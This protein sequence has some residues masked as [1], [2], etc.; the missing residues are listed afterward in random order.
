MRRNW[1]KTLIPLGI[2]VLVGTSV[3]SPVAAQ[4]PGSTFAIAG[5][6]RPARILVDRWGVP[7]VYAQTARD[8]FLAQGFNAARDRLFQIDLW[9]RKGLGRLSE[10][11][12]PDFVDQDRAARLFR[13]RGDMRAEWESYGPEGRLAATR[14]ANG[15]NAYLDWLDRNASA[16]PEEFRKL[17]YKPARWAP[18]DVVTIRA[19]VLSYNLDSEIE[20]AR[21]ACAAGIEADRV[22]VR[23]QPEHRPQ[24]PAGFDP[25][26]LPEDVLDVFNLA[27]GDLQFG[28]DDQAKAI[29][30]GVNTQGSNAWTLGPNRTTTGRPILANDPHRSVS[31]PSPRYLAHLSAPGLNVIGAGEP[32]APG[33]SIGHNDTAGFGLTVS[34]IDQEDLYVYQLD[35]ADPGRYR[36]RDGWENLTKVTEEIPVAGAAPRKVELAFTRHGPVIKVDSQRNLAYAVRAAWLEP[37]MSP[38]YGSLRY[39]RAKSFGEFSAA[40]GNWGAPG[41]N[42]V[43]ADTRGDIGLT[44]SGRAPRRTGYDGLLPVPGDGR[45]EWTGYVPG[46]ELPRYHNPEQGFLATGNEYNLPPGYPEKLGYEWADPSRYDRIAEVLAGKPKSSVDDSIRLQSDQLSPI[47]RSLLPKLEQLSSA[48]PSAAAALR[49]LRGWDAVEHDRSA[50]A[51]LFEVWLIG[52]LGPR[53]TR[54]IL[55]SA[56]ADLVPFPDHTVLIEAM[57]QPDKWFGPGGAAKRDK[58]LLDSLK[59]AYQDAAKRLGPDPAQW[60]WGGL[61]KT[62]FRHPAASKVDDPTAKKWNVGPFPRGGSWNTVNISVFNPLTYEHLGGASFRMV[63]DVGDWDASRA[64]N[65]PGQSGDPNGPHYRD[66]AERWRVGAAVPLLYGRGAVEANTTQRI[67]LVP[68]P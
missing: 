35:P 51:A 60:R 67:E 43:Y 64:I 54:T 61:L 37:G 45:Y 39:L 53:F 7:H 1:R 66:L 32:F 26:T 21:V 46:Q 10:V 19:H 38:Y 17:G 28:D 47:A 58:V 42:H 14:F 48:D 34:E 56:A 2:A 68:K 9:L 11:F 41:M 62:T 36:Y 55:P 44:V 5:L 49:L 6:D 30:R 4:Q 65:T 20:R 24:V 16:L 12:G 3:A 18:E 33:L 22:R 23:L 40:T 29:P 59:T 52:H 8:A 31:A 25:C 27:K 63:L 13:Y 15:V 57:E 50:P